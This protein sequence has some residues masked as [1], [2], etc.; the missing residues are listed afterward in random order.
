MES[1]KCLFIQKAKVELIN[2][3]D[4]IE[5]V[6]VEEFGLRTVEVRDNSF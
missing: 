4:E 5:D 6:Y 1:A 2:E 3:N